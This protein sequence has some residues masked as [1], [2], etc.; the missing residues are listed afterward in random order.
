[1]DNVHPLI[2]LIGVIIGI[3][4]FGFIGLVFGPIIISLFFIILKMYKIEYV[5]KRF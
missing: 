4:L 1:M 2:T 5:D 3:P